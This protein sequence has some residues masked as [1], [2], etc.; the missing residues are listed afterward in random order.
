METIITGTLAPVRQPDRIEYSPLNGRQTWAVYQ[1]ADSALITTAR[2]GY[3]TSGQT[4]RSYGDGA[5]FTVEVLQEG[6]ESETYALQ[7]SWEIVANELQR[8]DFQSDMFYALSVANQDAVI[9]EV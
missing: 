3:E 1:S 2:E 7:D 5:I 8:G 6:A 4:C 9:A